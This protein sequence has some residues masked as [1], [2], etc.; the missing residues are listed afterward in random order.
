MKQVTLWKVTVEGGKMIPASQQLQPDPS[1]QQCLDTERHR[2]SSPSISRR[3]ET[4]KTRRREPR[5]LEE[6][7]SVCVSLCR[8]CG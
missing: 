5:I 7:R 6:E 8:S 1:V 4:E 2:L 3:G